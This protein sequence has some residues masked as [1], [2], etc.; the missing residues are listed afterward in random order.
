MKG[1][2]WV[3]LALGAVLKFVVIAGAARY[4]LTLPAA[5]AGALLL[6]Q[7]INAL[8]GGAVALP[9]ADHLR[10]LLPQER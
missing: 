6:P 7:L 3:G 1:G 4:L 2:S 8:V 9:I 10:R 5:A